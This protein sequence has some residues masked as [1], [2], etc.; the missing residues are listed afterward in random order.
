MRKICIVTGSRAEWGLLS[1]LARMIGNDPQLELQIIATN[2]HL[3]PEFGLTYREIE[4]DGFTID[5]KVEMLLSSDTANA[6]G[7]SVGLATIGFADAYEDL[8][9]DLLVVLGDRYELL[10]ALTAALFYKIPIAHLHGGE[11]TE[12]AYDDSIRHAITKMSHLHFTST[13]EYRR[14]VIQLGEDPERVFNVGAIGIDNIRHMQL[15]KKEELEK[16]L[17]F[18]LTEKTVLVTYHPVTLETIS[19]EE[20]IDNLLEALETFPN[21]NVIFTLPNSDTDG[22]I[23]IRKIN[24]FVKV[25]SR[26]SIA[27]PSLGQL[28]YFSVL[29]YI[30]AVIG[31]SSSGI[32][33]VPSFGKFTLDI[34]ERQKGRLRADSIFHCG[35]GKN[36]IE[37]GIKEILELS[38]SPKRSVGTN[39]YDKPETAFHI[40]HTLKTFP[41]T[42]I[43]CKHFY[44]LP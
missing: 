29:Q 8:K 37:N 14:R 40:F 18:S 4:K 11:I 19:A 21:L 9:P 13:E 15:L 35:T 7:K 26:R 20:Q 6:T 16:S 34:G 42:N 44:N 2:M 30:H 25:N 3:S 17:H 28:R 23:I 22:R 12:G 32:L 27:F 38:L 24:D 10:A 31:N 41:L 39:P 1:R 43:V 33:E 5:K 36:E